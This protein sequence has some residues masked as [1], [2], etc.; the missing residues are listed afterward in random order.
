[1]LRGVEYCTPQCPHY[2]LMHA[3]AVLMVCICCLIDF[4]PAGS[5]ILLADNGL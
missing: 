3:I 2:M 1:M 5:L 4:N